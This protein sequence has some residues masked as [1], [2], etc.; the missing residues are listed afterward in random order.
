MERRGRDRCEICQG[1]TKTVEGILVCRN[2]LCPFN[3]KDIECPRCSSL[4]PDALGYEGE[5]I[6]YKCGDCLNTWMV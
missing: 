2:S 5:K 4:G 3:H 1:P 6:R